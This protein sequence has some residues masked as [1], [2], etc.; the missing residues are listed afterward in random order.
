[1][2]IYLDACC[3]SRLT[4]DQS[5]VRIREEAEAIEQILGLV[6][7]GAVE[8]ISSEALRHEIRRNPSE[9]RRVE[10]EALVSLAIATVEMDE[11]VVDRANELEAA[12]YG[13]YDAFH[14]ASAESARVG[15]LLSTDDRLLKLAARGIGTPRVAVRN[16]VS[17]IK[18]H[19]V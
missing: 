1:M 19:R 8:L 2:K 9:E 5:Q 3:F 14:V 17:W 15:V 11:N 7:L 4:D 13:A 12:G 18:E 6:R 10:C 16:P